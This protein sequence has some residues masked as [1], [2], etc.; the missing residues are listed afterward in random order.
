MKVTNKEDNFNKDMESKSIKQKAR[1]SFPKPAVPYMQEVTALCN[2]QEV[3]LPR[4]VA[5]LQTI[6]KIPLAASNRSLCETPTS[7]VNNRFFRLRM[8]RRRLEFEDQENEI[9]RFK[10][11]RSPQNITVNNNETNS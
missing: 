7:T 10:S 3:P 6:Q 5:L 11:P 4:V 9:S 8:P 2:T 1:K